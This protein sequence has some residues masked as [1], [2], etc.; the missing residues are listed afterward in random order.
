MGYRQREPRSNTNGMAPTCSKWTAH[1]VEKGSVSTTIADSVIPSAP[2][3]I[4]E[5]AKRSS[6]DYKKG[7]DTRHG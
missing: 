3:L 6:A 4:V 1:D 2:A 5:A 7:G